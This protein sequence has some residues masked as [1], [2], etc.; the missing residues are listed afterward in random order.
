MKERFTII[1]IAVALAIVVTIMFVQGSVINSKNEEIAQLKKEATTTKVEGEIAR[2]SAFYAGY[3]ACTTG[4]IAWFNKWS[5]EFTAS[6]PKF[7]QF[8]YQAGTQWQP[9]K[10]EM[11]QYWNVYNGVE[12]DGV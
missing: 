10:E 7:A 3:D 2:K 1:G 4:D 8:L 9:T 11:E 5:G 6:Y 12:E